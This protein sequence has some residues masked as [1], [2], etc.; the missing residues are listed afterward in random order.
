MR[1]RKFTMLA[2]VL[3]LAGMV[4]SACGP[5]QPAGQ[6][7]QGGT[8]P[9]TTP[10]PV[11]SGK[12]AVG[13]E[14]TL[15][16]AKDPDSLNPI[17]SSSSYGSDVHGLVYDGLFIFN[18]KWEPVPH[19]AESYKVSED[20][21]TW[22]IPL[23]KG[24]KFHNGTELTAD[25]V[26]FTLSTV[27]DKDYTGPRASNVAAIKEVKAADSHTVVISLKEPYAP[28]LEDI[29]LGIMS[30]K[31]M[32]GTTV[33]DMDKHT[34]AFEPMG[35]GPY[36][37]VEYKRGQYVTL[38][39]NE[40]WFAG[41]ANGGAPFIETVRYKIIPE[42]ATAQAAIE[43]GEID[44]LPT[45]DPKEVA[46]IKTDFADKIAMYDYERNGWGY[47]TLNNTR[48]HLDNKL[49]RQALTYGLN[50]QSVVDGLMDGL[51]V[52]PGGPIPPVSWAYDSSIKP[53]AYDKAKA[54]QLLEQ[55]GY[56]MGANGI[57]EK[58]GQPLKLTFYGSSGSA[59]IEGIASIARNNWKEIGVE[60]DVQLMDFNALT[61]NYLKPGK[62][63]ITFAGMSLSLDPDQ[64][65]LFHSTMVSGFNRGRYNNPK[66][67][68]LLEQGTKES[69]P[70]KR[71]AIYSEYQK[72]FVEDAP[73]IF[74]YAN[75]YTDFVSKRVKGV[76]NFPGGGADTG[77]VWKWYVNEQ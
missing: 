29:S 43:A 77:Y 26:V 67:D 10:A 45:P 66:V 47:M 58:D 59:L 65:G 16:L 14:I 9:G 62:F 61:D 73:V 64:T 51:A 69:D 46:R 34:S 6:A 72:L 50:R 71:K 8:A 17:L 41:Q 52:I 44:A 63:D 75:K 32:E 15:R 70:A 60:I 24:V 56:K 19:L 1:S 13:G 35:T 54:K 68:A 7:N 25:D 57:Y 31:Y 74:V 48:P 18:E 30:K 11:S 38:K 36:K 27:M 33:A 37:M 53:F 21:L 76:F 23:K 55:A 49:V 3:V 40:N 20:G 42:D 5:K 22:T 39:R 2:S 28:L 4:L 12:P